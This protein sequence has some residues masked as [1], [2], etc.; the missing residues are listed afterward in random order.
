MIN[1]SQSLGLKTIFIR[2]NPDV[3]MI[4]NKTQNV[5]NNIRLL[6]LKKW[7]KNLIKNEPKEF[8]S[9]VYLF[10]DEYLRNNSEIIP[11]LKQE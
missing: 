2:Y 5:N 11:I 1:I 9:V 10:F 8:L 6:I 4:E 7:L 3:Y